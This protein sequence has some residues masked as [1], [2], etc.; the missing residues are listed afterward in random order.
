MPLLTR[1]AEV[2][3][4]IPCQTMT[5]VQIKVTARWE[6]RP[7]R[8]R[9]NRGA[10]QDRSRGLW[11]NGAS[12]FWLRPCDGARRKNLRAIPA[13]LAWIII[14]L[15]LIAMVLV[16]GVVPFVVLYAIG[17]LSKKLTVKK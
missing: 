13:R 6:E 11:Q 7:A 14:M 9:T 3:I 8:R 17:H 1:A 12:R 15:E 4:S 5:R 2:W 16:V 10:K